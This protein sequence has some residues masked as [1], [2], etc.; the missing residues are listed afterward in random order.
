MW[1]D[2]S[3]PPMETCGGSL[4]ERM[5]FV[6]L[7]LSH[8]LHQL[9]TVFIYLFI[10]V[11]LC[12]AAAAVC[13]RSAFFCFHCRIDW[14][15][16]FLLFSDGPKIYR[17]NKTQRS[18]CFSTCLCLFKEDFLLLWS[19]FFAVH[20]N[21]T[22]KRFNKYQNKAY[23]QD[24]RLKY[25]QA[26][27]KIL[28]V[29]ISNIDILIPL[30]ALKVISKIFRTTLNLLDSTRRHFY[31]NHLSESGRKHPSRT[32]SAT[33]FCCFIFWKQ[34]MLSECCSDPELVIVGPFHSQHYKHDWRWF[35]TDVI[36]LHW[37][38]S[39]QRGTRGSRLRNE[40][41]I[42]PRLVMWLGCGSKAV[43]SLQTNQTV[44]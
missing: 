22:I 21:I 27:A 37:A 35:A 23:W 38:R 1:R 29:W 15:Q 4:Q 2:D 28:S 26:C 42:F 24:M 30:K 44:I 18:L 25:W 6:F 34:H 11:I 31:Q 33:D 32:N 20:K 9:L 41:R 17:R 19:S 3:S 5:E 14:C 8:P 16:Q 43:F 13:V 7:L 40:T 12:F 39:F 10:S 36:E